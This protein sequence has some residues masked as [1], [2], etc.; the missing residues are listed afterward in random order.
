MIAP[1]P[2]PIIFSDLI[3]N[4]DISP[5][6]PTGLFLNVAPKA[7]LASSITLI[8]SFLQ[9]AVISRISFAGKP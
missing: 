7:S 2:T 1:S 3:E 9:Y 4:T 6:L 5:K 8:L